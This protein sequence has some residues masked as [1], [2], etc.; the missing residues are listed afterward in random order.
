MEQTQEGRLHRTDMLALA[1]QHR[2]TQ[3]H[4]SLLHFLKFVAPFPVT[5]S[6]VA[7]P[8]LLLHLASTVASERP[9]LI[10]ECGSGVSTLVMARTAQLLSRTTRVVSLEHDPEYLKRSRKLLEMHDAQAFAEIRYAPL[11]PVDLQDHESAWYARDQLNDLENIDLLLIDGPPTAVGPSAR[12]PAVPLL[13]ERLSESATVLLDDAARKDEADVAQRWQTGQLLDF[14]RTDL[15]LS[16]G[17][18]QFSRGRDT[19]ETTP[20]PI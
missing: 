17:L 16:R 12:F 9:Q 5:D 6:F 10:V 13:H 20:S 15:R 18:A 11:E 7:A 3:A 14:E 2:Q 8:D 19:A 1:D 4:L